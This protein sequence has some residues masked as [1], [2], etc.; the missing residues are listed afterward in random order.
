MVSSS[1]SSL[2]SGAGDGTLQELLLAVEEDGLVAGDDIHPLPQQPAYRVL[3]Q[4]YHRHLVVH[5]P[6]KMVK[7]VMPDHGV[8]LPLGLLVCM[9]VEASGEAIVA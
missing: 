7:D 4:R 2:G 3:V 5:L 9:V 8:G 6:G 1:E